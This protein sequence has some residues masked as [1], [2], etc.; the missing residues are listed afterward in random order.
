MTTT[1]R[2]LELFIR[3]GRTVAQCR[4]ETNGRLDDPV[5][6]D[7]AG[8]EWSSFLS[9]WGHTQAAEITVL[10]KQLEQLLGER[11]LLQKEVDK[12]PSLLEQIGTIKQ[13]KED[14]AALTQQ[15]SAVTGERNELLAQ[16]PVIPL[17]REEVDTLRQAK[18]DLEVEVVRLTALVP[19]PL[20]PREVTPREFLSRLSEEDR[21]AIWNSGDP[22][23]AFAMMEL[24][25]ATSINLD[26]PVLAGMIDMLVEAGVDIDETER[27]R[28]FA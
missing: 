12:I 6:I 9:E 2:H 16:V 17:L 23:C 28:I 24:F 11:D 8:P 14:V 19:P 10:V 7:V 13:L 15:L 3:D 25:S 1:P 5:T 22:R 21:L 18:N 27:A 26:S 4:T 20:S